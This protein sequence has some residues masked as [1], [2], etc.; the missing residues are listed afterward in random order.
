MNNIIIIL[1]LVFIIKDNRRH[2]LENINHIIKKITRR[3]HFLKKKIFL[4]CNSPYI[5]SYYYV[6][7]FGLMYAFLFTNNY[8]TT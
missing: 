3:K 8:V 4:S 7:F 5:L 1:I 2:K 6:Q